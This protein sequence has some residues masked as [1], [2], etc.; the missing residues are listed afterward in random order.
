MT[1]IER[2]E[3]RL[4]GYRRLVVLYGSDDASSQK[5]AWNASIMRDL[6]MI[7]EDSF[8]LASLRLSAVVALWRQG[9]RYD[10]ME[11]FRVKDRAF[12]KLR[13][14]EFIARVRED[15]DGPITPGP[16]MQDNTHWRQAAE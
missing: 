15:L 13:A 8:L 9:K 16:G 7:D 4:F 3:M 14:R 6:D 2:H 12:D 1:L 10:R 5:L 11:I